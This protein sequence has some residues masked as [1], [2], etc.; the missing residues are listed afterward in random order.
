MINERISKLRKLMA[1][2]N[3]DAYIVPSSDPHQSEYLADYYKTRQFITGFTGS[4]GTAVITTKKSGLWTD[5]R[6]F[7]QAAKE[8]SV[9]EVELYKMGV[10]DSISIE[11]FLL[12]EFPN[13]VAKIAFDGN[14]TSVAEYENLMRKLPNFEFITDVDY[15]GD[16]WNEEGRPAKPDSKVYIFDEKYSGESTS[17]RIARLRSMMKERGIDYHFIGSLD[18]IAYVLNIR[19]NDVQCNPVVIS[20]LLIS[21]NTCNLYIDKSKLS[22][23]VADYLKENNISIKSYEVIARDISDIEAKKTL[24]LETKKTNVAVYSSIGRGVNVVTGLNLTSIMKCHKNEIEIKNT[25]NAFIKDGVALVR[26][27]NWLETGVST[28]TITEMIASEKLLEFRKQQDLFI[29]DSFEA[30]SAYG[31]NASMPHYKPSHEHPVKVEPRGLYLID[32]GGHYLDGTTDITRT[33]ALGELKEEEI[34]H[35]TLVLKAHI[36]LMEAKFLEGT[37]GGYLDA[38]TRYNLWK[39][40]IN[41]NHG[42]G[43]GVGHVLNV[44]EG[45]QRIGTAGNEYPMEVGMV[46]SDEPGIYISGSHGIRIESIM[47]CVKDEMTE[48][49][50]FLKFDNLTVVPIDTRPVDKSLLTEEEIVWL[51]DY[52]KMCYEKL[53]PYLSGHDLEYLREQCK[54]I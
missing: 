47:V 50:Q 45:P 46:T 52:N 48:F 51:N 12:K 11:E 21:E 33:V 2:R 16:I 22:Q 24:Y 3:I 19:A 10:P 31:A 28:G 18:D 13:G 15:I 29:E 38:F 53:S 25:K 35:Y 9:G 42:T 4:A 27:L 6:Y 41:F 44:H 30:I 49:G 23:E 54:E 37:N 5:G 39:N 34:Y 1:K 20:Y 36:A 17:D 40:R 32:S 7:I 26:Y 14:N 8:L 43:H